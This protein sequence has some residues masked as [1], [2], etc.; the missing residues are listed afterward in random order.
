MSANAPARTLQQ[1]ILALQQQTVGFDYL[2]IALAVGVLLWHCISLW[3]YSLAAAIF[4]GPWRFLP[5]VILPAFFALS[6]F[7]VAGSLQRNTLYRFA[8]LRVLRIVPALAF[9]TMLCALLLG[10]IFT[11]LPLREYF[12]S[13]EFYAYFGNIVGDIHY[14]LPGVFDGKVLNAQLWTIPSE[15]ECYLL[16][17]AAGA[18]GLVRRRAVFAALLVLG[19]LA[20]TAYAMLWMPVA[21]AKPLP[22][23]ILVF[24]F[25]AGVA[26]YLY[27]DRVRYSVG[28]LAAA[29]AASVLMLNMAQLSYLAAMPVAYATV[30]LG[31]TR[32]PRIPFGDLSYGVYLFHFPVARTLWEVLGA[33]L[34]WWSLAL[35]TLLATTLCAAI[36]WTCIEKPVLDR[37][38][39]ALAW[40]DTC[41]SVG[42]L[43]LRSWL[44]F[45]G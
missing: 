15:F 22:G 27:R 2:R 9:E 14:T 32:P 30:W 10:S 19:C 13:A 21:P 45:K 34:S 25:L 11:T 1:Q 31:L 28:W 3:N 23:R 33:W 4:I 35:C 26:L 37:K 29:I 24:S 36:S 6:G 41:W 40:L 16:L 42:Q 18:A 12:S 17:I 39:T 20:F 43:R 38:K 5:V 44:R 8:A 7:L